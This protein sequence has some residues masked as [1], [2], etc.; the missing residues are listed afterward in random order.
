[1]TT[2]VIRHPMRIVSPH[3]L[4]PQPLRQKLRKF[5]HLRQQSIHL[6]LQLFILHRRRHL[7]IVIPHHRHT[8]RRRH[9]YRLSPFKL[10]DKSLQQ[11]HS[12]S[13]IPRVVVHL[14]A[15]GL[16]RRKLHRMPQPLQ[17][18]HHGLAS[19]GKQR[20]VIAGN[21]QRNS[22][23]NLQKLRSKGNSIESIFPRRNSSQVR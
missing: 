16:P 7:R 12:L 18:S 22:Q 20:V 17:Q 14:S 13:L 21:K 15:A 10:T 19:L 3:I 1:M 5:K 6:P 2:R 23:T 11:R 4:Q 8:R 9:H